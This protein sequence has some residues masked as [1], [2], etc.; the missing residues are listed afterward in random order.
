MELVIN[1][2][3]NYLYLLIVPSGENA[4]HNTQLV[5]PCNVCLGVPV[6][7]SHMRAVLSPEPVTNSEEEAGENCAVK[8]GSPCPDIDDAHRETGFTLKTA[9]G[10]YDSIN[11]SSVLTMPGFTSPE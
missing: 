1:P 10:E 2:V 3:Y 8:I 5:C 11:S 6:S 4:T 9:C 7:Q